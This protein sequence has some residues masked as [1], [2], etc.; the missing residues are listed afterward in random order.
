MIGILTKNPEMAEQLE[1][2]VRPKSLNSSTR[3]LVTRVGVRWRGCGGSD[4]AIFGSDR[5]CVYAVSGSTKHSR[6]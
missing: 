6:H 2:Y 1:D 5:R 3:C 4:L